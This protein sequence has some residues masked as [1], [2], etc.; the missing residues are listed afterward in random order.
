MDISP[1][2]KLSL[3]LCGSAAGLVSGMALLMLLN[4]LPVWAMPANA[5]LRVGIGVLLLFLELLVAGQ[6]L[7][8]LRKPTID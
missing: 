4:Q 3:F 6:L 7:H 1:L 8:T 5:E 2:E